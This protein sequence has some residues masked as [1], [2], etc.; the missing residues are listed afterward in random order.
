MP[1]ARHGYALTTHKLQGQ[2]LDSLVIDVGPDRD[3]ASAYV[4]LTRHRNDVVAVVNAADIA[5]GPW[6]EQLMKATPDARRDAVVTMVSE[7]MQ[8]RGFRTQPTAHH[9]AG[10]HFDRSRR[11]PG[12]GCRCSCSGSAPALTR[13]RTWG[14]TGSE[15]GS[16]RWPL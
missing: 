9:S 11:A 14:S 5:E 13:S 4:A 12:W 7:R 10:M 15:H 1:H 2:T 3:M 6:V 8:R 16:P